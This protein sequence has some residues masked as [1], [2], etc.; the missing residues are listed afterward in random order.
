[1]YSDSYFHIMRTFYMLLVNKVIFLASRGCLNMNL[2][3]FGKR[4]RTARKQCGM[5]SEKLSEECNL[6]PVF[7]RQLEAG[8][9]APSLQ[10]LISLCNAMKISPSYLLENELKFNESETT[11]N[12]SARIKELSPKQCEQIIT[13]IDTFFDL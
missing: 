13:V 12:L 10:T 6:T 1:M 7:I 5:T 8:I 2:K 3:E 4:V 11:L 9:K